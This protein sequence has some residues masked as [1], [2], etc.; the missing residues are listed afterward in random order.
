MLKTALIRGGVRVAC[1]AVAGLL[2][3]ACGGV[4][5]LP[6]ADAVTP[7][8]DPQDW[9]G[10]K[11]PR[12]ADPALEARIQTI[13]ATMS[14]RDKVAQMTQAEIKSATPKDV[15][16]Y[17]LGSVLNG[18]GSWPGRKRHAA[19][20]DW[21][22]LAQRYHDASLAS[23]AEVPIPV[24]WGTDAVHGHNNVFG[25]TLFPHNI[26][27]GAAGD[28]ELV[29]EM[30][31]AV[32]KAVRATGVGWVFAP[33]VAVA[34]DGRWGRTY[35]SFSADPAVVGSYARA[36]VEGLQGSLTGDDDVVATAKH[37]IGDGATFRGVDQGIARVP[38]HELMD[39]HARGYY[40][41]L[42]AGVQTVMVSYSSW[43]DADTGIAW[44][45]MHG[46]R[47][48]LTDVLKGRLGFDGLVVSDWNAI[49]QVPGCAIDSCAA[50]INA[51]VDMVMVPHDWKD[52][53][54]K[55]V[56]QVER[57]EI[58]LSRI[59]DAVTR[60]LRVKLRAGLF[61]RSP[62]DSAHAGDGAA[63][64]AKD[65]A[66]RAV[67]ES[68]VLLKNDGGVLPLR[69]GARLLVVGKGADSLP[70][71]TGGWSL[72]WQGTETDNA[73]FPGGETLLAALRSMA[74]DV[75]LV[76]SPDGAGADPAAF[77]AV[78][79]VIGEAPY[80]ETRGD[81]RY[82]ATLSHSRRYPEDLE[83]LRAVAGRGAPVITVFLTGR[84]QYASDL[85]N[86]SD[87]FVVAW[88]PGTEAAG[89]TDVLY[90]D[91]DG[92]IRFDF[93]GRLPF[94]WPAGPCQTGIAR[95]QA[96]GGPLF[97]LG[98]GLG[99]G[100]AGASTGLVDTSDAATCDAPGT[101]G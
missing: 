90:R 29:G 22:E 45:K 46:N 8:G 88:L 28:P 41:A 100:D 50:A 79:A 91:A 10:V 83:V 1:L 42:E 39:V 96:D 25:G 81:V 26:G 37:F 74:G 73:D 97:P 70:M 77:D 87:A 86:L 3:A 44:G 15:R 34:Q 49:E 19:V 35:E 99:Y 93:R 98:F 67:R 82:P 12:P 71:Q 53:I 75:E 55:T 6:V 80:A 72:T 20:G 7:P 62:R 24:I 84:P 69:R 48:L 4:S 21:L 11:S 5:R 92:G 47:W 43:T 23:G 27:L 31:R 65:L 60:I 95:A 2:V 63:L 16:R 14:L 89:I 66:R 78:I 9:P 52:F 68:L 32:G 101:R 58:P 30:A 61:D 54:R 33:T 85:I 13:L 51:G 64:L 56:R 36:Y 40:A 18:G 59:D 38:L 94:A 17:R 57:G 76:H